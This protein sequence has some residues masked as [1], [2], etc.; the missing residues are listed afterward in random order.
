MNLALDPTTRSLTTASLE[1]FDTGDFGLLEILR[2]SLEHDL[3][4]Q[5]RAR[6]LEAIAPIAAT[7]V[8]QATTFAAACVRHYGSILRDAAG[9]DAPSDSELLG[10]LFR[11]FSD[12]SRRI[13]T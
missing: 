1:G 8:S 9:D 3:D 2:R 7:L 4:E 10:D 5:A 6:G 13:P 11:C 12:G